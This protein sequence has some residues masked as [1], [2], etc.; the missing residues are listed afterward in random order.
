MKIGCVLMAAGASVRFGSNKLLAK[1]AGRP[2]VL[3]VMDN[4]PCESLARIVV[5]SPYD[6]VARLAEQ[7][8]F[9]HAKPD[10]PE[11]ND[12]VRAGIRRM[13]GMDGCLFCLGDQPLCRK[14]SMERMI[15]IFS[16][17]PDSIV[18]LYYGVI[19]GNP[20]LFPKEIFRELENLPRKKGGSWTLQRHEELLA[21]AQAVYPWELDDADTPETLAKMEALLQR[22]HS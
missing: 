7:A 17:R 2:L 20:I 16:E 12:T 9:A 10:G 19:P 14:D 13:A 22:I 1:L 8:G 5:V 15:E 3:H 21:Q 18:R 6:E 4:L 11:R